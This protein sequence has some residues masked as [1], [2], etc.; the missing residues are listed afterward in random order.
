MKKNNKHTAS[1]FSTKNFKKCFKCGYR[2][3]KPVQ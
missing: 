3:P 1:S 2:P